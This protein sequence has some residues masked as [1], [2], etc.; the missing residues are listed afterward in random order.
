MEREQRTSPSRIRRLVRPAAYLLAF[1]LVPLAVG[2]VTLVTKIRNMSLTEPPAFAQALPSPPAHDPDRMTAVVLASNRTTESTDFL[3]PFEVLAASGAFNVYAVAPERRVSHLFPGTLDI[4]PH[5]GFAEYAQAIG[6][7]PDLIVVPFI[8]DAGEH[9]R[10]LLAWIREHAGEHTIILTI[11][12]GS[13]VLAETGLLEGQ[14]ATSHQ[15][16]LRVVRETDPE[17]RWI[18]GQRYV[19]DGNVIS[20]AGI[21]SG[22]DATLFTLRRMQGREVAAEVAQRLGYPHTHFQDDPTFEVPRRYGPLAYLSAAYRWKRTNVGVVLYEGVGE[23][24][25][26]SLLDTYPRSFAAQVH[27]MASERK[28]IRSRHG[29]DL[30]PRLA[31]GKAPVLDRV[32]VPGSAAG[33]TI[34]GLDAWAAQQRLSVERV[35]GNGFAY[36]VALRDMA[37][38]ETSALA[39]AAA[40]GLEY[41]VDHLDLDAGCPVALLLRPLGLG[42]LGMALVLG[43]DRGLSARRK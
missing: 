37:R 39:G 9:E 4:L 25:L 38:Q 33:A 2:A 26:A 34:P 8:P 28:V 21:T 17:V 16:V 42:L 35:H 22:I 12:G 13:M 6:R 3:A 40:A 31:F 32:L 24:E 14:R 41:P 29:L 7:A 15:S 10:P 30:V 36:D 20:S 18:S 11:C 1:L 19:E 43:I 27:T 5:Y 23:I